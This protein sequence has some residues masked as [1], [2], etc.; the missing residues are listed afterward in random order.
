MEKISSEQY[1]RMQYIIR[2][3]LEKGLSRVESK[4]IAN[5]SKNIVEAFSVVENEYWWR[6]DYALEWGKVVAIFKKKG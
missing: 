3:L 1:K 5:V 2:S 4:K 6:D